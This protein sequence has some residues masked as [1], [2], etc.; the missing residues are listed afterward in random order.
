MAG[1]EQDL[2]GVRGFFQPAQCDS[3]AFIIEVGQGVVKYDGNS[4]FSRKNAIADSQSG[5]QIQLVYCSGGEQSGVPV[6]GVPRGLGG[7]M[8]AAV[9]QEITEF[10]TFRFGKAREREE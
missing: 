7:E 3:A 4:I 5:G 10:V 6:Y 8:E 1:E 9:Q 2:A